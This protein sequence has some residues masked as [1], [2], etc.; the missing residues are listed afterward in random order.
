MAISE[1][2]IELNELPAEVPIFPLTGAL[3][4]PGGHLPLNIF[5]PRYIAMTDAALGRGRWLGMVQPRDTAEQTVGDHHPVFPVGCLGRIVAFK[6]TEG[7]RY[8]IT[9]EGVCRFRI[10]RELELRD[11]YRAAEAR[12]GGFAND[13]EP[14]ALTAEA[15]DALV[16]ALKAYFDD[17][18]FDADWAA[19]DAMADDVLVASMAMACPFSA[20]EKQALLE[21]P[22]LNERAQSLITILNMAAHSAAPTEDKPAH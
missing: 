20:A 19:L 2:D 21:A 22:G 18:G 17:R 14:G 6:E 10:E 4:L 7:G 8:L 1:A 11:N 16:G 5:E 9:L 3:L 12:Y 15:R 13:L